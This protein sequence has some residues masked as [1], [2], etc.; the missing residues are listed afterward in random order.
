MYLCFIYVLF[1]INCKLPQAFMQMVARCKD[2]KSPSQKFSLEWIHFLI[3]I[4][5]NLP[6]LATMCMHSLYRK[7]VIMI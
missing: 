4:L 6:N 2:F 5:L 7:K 3:N 1:W